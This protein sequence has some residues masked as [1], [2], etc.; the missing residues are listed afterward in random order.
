[1]TRAASLAETNKTIESMTPRPKVIIAFYASTRYGSEYRAGVEFIQI[2]AANGFSI[3]IVADLEQNDSPGTLAAAAPGISV[4]S[5]PSP[6]RRQKSL[7]R[8]SDFL[9]QVIWH[10]RV[11]KWLKRQHPDVDVLWVQN[12]ALP[13]LP[14]SPYFPVARTLVWGPVGGGESPPPLLM[15]ELRWSSRLREWL[16]TTLESFALHRKQRQFRGESAPAVVALARTSE[17]QRRLQ[18]LFPDGDIPV[19]PE[20]LEPVQPATLDR[21]PTLAPRFVWV[22]QDIP[23]KNLALALSMFEKLRLEAFPGSTLDVFGASR[24]GGAPTGVRFHGWVPRVDWEG[25]RHDGILLLTSFREGLPSVVLEAVSNGLLCITSDVGSLSSLRLAT[26][27]TLPKAE[28]PK[29]SSDTF[30]SMVTSIRHH[31][32]QS[33]VV[34]S[35]VSHRDLLLG[36]LT[37]KGIR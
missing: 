6:V 30:H 22:G 17:A 7:Y 28:Y 18:P 4:A 2:A 29:Y 12:G 5:I 15:R 26:I 20:I 33:Q 31:L 3:A 27:K 8:F 16:R 13:W 11:A 37:A 9:P 35:P 32:S 19:I 34:L 25:Y 23:R 24:D 10:R 14:L 36:H 21:V 1:M